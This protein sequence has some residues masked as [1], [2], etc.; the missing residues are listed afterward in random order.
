MCKKTVVD[1][2][3]SLLRC[4]PIKGLP[5]ENREVHRVCAQSHR[6]VIATC[7]LELTGKMILHRSVLSRLLLLRSSIRSYYRSNP[8]RVQSTPASGPGRE[9]HVTRY[10]NAAGANDMPTRSGG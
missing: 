10:F 1:A 3:C 2:Q 4:F 8:V 5:K 9:D 7:I 6:N